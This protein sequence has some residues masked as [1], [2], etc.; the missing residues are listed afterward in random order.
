MAR[1]HPFLISFDPK[2]KEHLR[3]IDAKHHS[4]IRKTIR[5]QLEYE[6]ETETTNR[7]P[8][9]RPTELGATWELRIGPGNRFRVLYAVDEDLH[10]VQI[11]AIGIKQGNR[12]II[13]G[14]EVD[15]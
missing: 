5:D 15:L 12:L 6:P 1:K 13:G 3:Y 11:L 7:K 10:E 8:L 9:Q 4:L 2:V 14:E